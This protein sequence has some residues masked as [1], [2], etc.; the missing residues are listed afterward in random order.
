MEAHEESILRYVPKKGDAGGKAA[1]LEVIF[2]MKGNTL[3]FLGSER[4]EVGRGGEEGWGEGE[5]R[6]RI[7]EERE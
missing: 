2:P 1:E 7:E 6:E 5:R 3:V 4:E